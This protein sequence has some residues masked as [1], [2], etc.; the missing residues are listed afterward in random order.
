MEWGKGYCVF[1]LAQ[2]RIIDKAVPQE[3]GAPM[4]NAVPDSRWRGKLSVGQELS[5]ADDGIL[6]ARKERGFRREILSRHVGC[7]KFGVGL[8]DCFRLP[9]HQCFGFGTP[10]AIQPKLQRG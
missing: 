5:D 4:D 10:N 2:N 1:Q 6:L 9:G 7:V 3:A 8:P